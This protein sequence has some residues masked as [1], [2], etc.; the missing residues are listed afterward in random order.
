M[1]LH[2]HA[3]LVGQGV[4]PEQISFAGVWRAYRRALREYRSPPDPG[5]RLK[6]LLDRALLDPYQRRNKRSRDYP[7]K[8]REQAAGPPLIRRATRA[9][10]Q[11]AKQVKREQKTGLTA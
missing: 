1:G 10:V 3:R 9:Q 2:A 5:E 4:L 8:K 7:C 6:Q 11:L